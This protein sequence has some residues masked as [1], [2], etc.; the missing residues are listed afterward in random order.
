M[1]GEF[2]VVCNCPLRTEI[3]QE[4]EEEEEEEEIR[5][6]LKKPMVTQVDMCD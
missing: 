6:R 3:C 5:I 1:A 2:E 4:E